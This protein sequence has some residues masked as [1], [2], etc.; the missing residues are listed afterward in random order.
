MAHC[1]AGKLKLP[2]QIGAVRQ[3]SGYRCS[4]ITVVP[5]QSFINRV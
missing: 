3:E 4:G 5:G 2:A 1:P